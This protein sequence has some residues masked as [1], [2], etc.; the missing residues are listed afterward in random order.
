MK[1]ASETQTENLRQLAQIRG[2]RVIILFKQFG[3][4]IF[5]VLLL[6]CGPLAVM[7]F[8]AVVENLCEWLFGLDLNAVRPESVVIIA[9]TIIAIAFMV[10]A[11]VSF[12]FSI[13]F[14]LRH[15]LSPRPVLALELFLGLILAFWTFAY[16]GVLT[17]SIIG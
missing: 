12:I 13:K 7:F 11:L 10:A 9:E 17:Y 15:C 3:D 2:N 14:R 1:S 16:V 6:G 4:F 5:G 8:P